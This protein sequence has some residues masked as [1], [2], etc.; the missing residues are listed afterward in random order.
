MEKQPPATGATTISSSRAIAATMFMAVVASSFLL[1]LPVLIGGL[2]GFG[3]TSSQIS[4]IAAA[5]L[6]GISLC[7]L[8]AA[9][10]INRVS[11]QHA[12]LVGLLLII[13]GN[14]ACY[15]VQD[16]SGLAMLRFAVGIG[17][18][19]LMPINLA[20]LARTKVP[21]RNFGIFIVL[22]TIHAMIGLALIP[23]LVAF[24]GVGATFILM[25]GL[26]LVVLP[27]LRWLPDSLANSKNDTDIEQTTTALRL[28]GK[29]L[30]TLGAIFFFF[31]VQSGI[32]T[33]IERI[34]DAAGISAETIGTALAAGAFAGLIGALTAAGIASKFGRAIPLTLTAVLQAVAIVLMRDHPQIAAFFL[35]SALF[36]FF[37]NF[38]IPYQMGVMSRAD[39]AGGYVVLVTAVTGI[40][41]TVGPLLGAALMEQGGTNV[42]LYTEAL[43]CAV[44]LALI[45]PVALSLKR[46]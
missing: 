11:W 45:L 25:A 12:A 4:V 18:G 42:F 1:F 2:S 43:L 15:W 38:G 34:G 9:Y 19:V 10:W 6:G 27:M 20:C 44:S 14:V 21:D 36:Q 16:F 7:S 22:Q 13:A 5:D 17:E 26:A 37:W 46:G 24:S 33:Y 35:A 32:W 8:A 30:L 31:A 29:A 41:F 40:G 3:L 23:Y 39:P 28:N